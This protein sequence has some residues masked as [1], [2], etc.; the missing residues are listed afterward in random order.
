MKE[1]MFT[2]YEDN[3]NEMQTKL[4]ELSKVLD[5]C[6]RLHQELMEAAQALSGLRASIGIKKQEWGSSGYPVPKTVTVLCMT[7]FTKENQFPVEFKLLIFSQFQFAEFNIHAHD[8][9]KLKAS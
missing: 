6:T 9:L 4:K 2:V 8:L 5:N 1:N 3:S 7:S